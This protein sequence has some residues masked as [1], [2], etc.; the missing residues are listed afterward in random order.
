MDMVDVKSLMM[1]VWQVGYMEAV[2][3]YEPL[4]D[5]IRKRDINKWLDMMCVD[6]K[7]F[8][9]LEKSGI[10]R[11]HKHGA[12]VNSPLVYSKTEIKKALATL[13]ADRIYNRDFKKLTY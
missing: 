13:R 10:I 11:T 6:K 7:V 12:G 5:E 2:R 9:R 4:R 3:A 8:K 1:E